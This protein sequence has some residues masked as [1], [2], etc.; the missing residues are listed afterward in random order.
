MIL[1][2]RIVHERNIKP[3]TDY[4]DFVQRVGTQ[5]LNKRT[6][7]ALIVSGALDCFGVQRATLNTSI[8][9]ALKYAAKQD[10]DAQSGQV[11]SFCRH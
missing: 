11:D 4:F 10:N 6:L 7:E 1:V 3:F 5:R 2:E 8:P 9:V